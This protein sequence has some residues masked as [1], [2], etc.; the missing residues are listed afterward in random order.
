MRNLPLTGGSASTTALVTAALMLLG[1]REAVGQLRREVAVTFDDLPVVA[2]V[3]TV[4]EDIVRAASA[5]ATSSG[6]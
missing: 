2:Y 6:Q 1:S 3:L 5:R 4:P